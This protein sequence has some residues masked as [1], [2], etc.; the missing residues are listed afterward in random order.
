MIC[1]L[2]SCLIF[3]Q[4][5]ATEHRTQFS[6][7]DGQSTQKIVRDAS[8]RHDHTP[9]RYSLKKRIYFRFLF[10]IPTQADWL[11]LDEV[12]PSHYVLLANSA[13]ISLDRLDGQR[14]SGNHR[15][16]WRNLYFSFS[17]FNS[18]SAPCGF[19]SLR[20]LSF[21]DPIYLVCTYLRAKV[22]LQAALGCL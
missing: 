22:V 10:Y 21:R 8:N 11:T 2:F 19:S 17:Y 6:P 18:T 7:S 14:S 5:D 9:L 4:L 12:R 3:R 20:T 15:F 13:Y 16:R 1:R